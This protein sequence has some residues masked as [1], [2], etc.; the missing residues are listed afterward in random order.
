MGSSTSPPPRSGHTLLSRGFSS[1]TPSSRPLEGS[2]TI[3]HSSTPNVIGAFPADH[4]LSASIGPTP[5][6]NEGNALNPQ[7]V[8]DLPLS[9]ISPLPGNH[10]PTVNRRSVSDTR[11]NRTRRPVQS[12]G[13]PIRR[14][15]RRRQQPPNLFGGRQASLDSTDY[16]PVAS[17]RSGSNPGDNG[18][19]SPLAIMKTA[20]Q[21]H[22]ELRRRVCKDMT[23]NDRKGVVYVIRDPERPHLLKIGA[24]MNSALRLQQ[25]ERQCGVRVERVYVS[26]EVQNYARAEHLV[27]GD[28]WHLCR[29]YWCSRCATEH[30]EW[31]E[32]DAALAVATVK[33]WVGF[34]EQRPYNTAGKLKAIWRHLISKRKLIQ[35]TDSLDHDNR[36]EHWAR[37]V[38]APSLIDHCQ[39]YVGV[40]ESHPIWPFL[41]KFSWQVSNVF[42]WVVVFSVLGDAISFL[43]LLSFF[44]CAWVSISAQVCPAAPPKASRER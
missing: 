19:T 42:A 44:A 13:S 21:V 34:M 36:W 11:H 7:A 24:T 25:I 31:H 23:P 22:E 33:R 6:S 35:A 5:Q 4:A 18:A 40:T 20:Q 14:P 12:Y 9:F 10:R 37:V 3:S 30:R 43:V 26:E 32:V 15:H 16:P 39:H 38:L 27:H 2:A 29:P 8:M 41:W 28:L 1:P 17:S